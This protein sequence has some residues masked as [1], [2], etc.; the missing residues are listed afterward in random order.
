MLNKYKNIINKDLTIE[1][2]RSI[3]RLLIE[4]VVLHQEKKIEI[5]YRFNLNTDNRDS[6]SSNYYDNSINSQINGR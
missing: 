5:V 3:V 6:E 1:D 4:K 2:K